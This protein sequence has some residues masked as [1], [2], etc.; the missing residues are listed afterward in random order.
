MYTRR[1]RSVGMTSPLHAV[2]VVT[3]SLPAAAAAAAQRWQLQQ[4]ALAGQ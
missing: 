1:L 4:G 3:A 2:A